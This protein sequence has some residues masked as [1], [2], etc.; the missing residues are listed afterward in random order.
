MPDPIK[1]QQDE[2]QR[3]KENLEAG[4]ILEQKNADIQTIEKYKELKGKLEKCTSYF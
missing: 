4:A 2:I 3:I 1:Q